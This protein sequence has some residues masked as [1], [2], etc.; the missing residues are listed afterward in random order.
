MAGEAASANA[1]AKELMER[2]VIAGTRVGVIIVAGD[3]L[4]SPVLRAGG[5]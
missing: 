1:A 5:R 4:P 2:R 3:A